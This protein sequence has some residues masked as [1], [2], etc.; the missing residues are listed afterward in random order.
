MNIVLIT[1]RTCGA[2]TPQRF[3]HPVV[4]VSFQFCVVLHVLSSPEFEPALK[5]SK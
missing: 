2:A 1:G 5:I 3:L 4:D